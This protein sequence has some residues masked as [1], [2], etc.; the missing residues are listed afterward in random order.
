[1]STLSLQ[2]PRN[3]IDINNEEMEYIDGGGT[4]SLYISADTIRYAIRVSSWAIGSF[5]GALAGNSLAGPLG[6]KVGATLGGILGG[7]IGNVV[8]SVI[9]GN[10]VKRGITVNLSHYLIPGKFSWSI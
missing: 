10:V 3:F 4:I 6:G 8:G 9:A 7:M 2:L 5:L 1:M